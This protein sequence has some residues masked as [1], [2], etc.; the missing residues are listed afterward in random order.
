MRRKINQR[1]LT[2]APRW[3]LDA[4]WQEFRHG[5]VQPDFA[6][7]HHI[8][9]KER[10][11]DLGNG[12][13]LEFRIAVHLSRVVLVQGAIGDNALALRVDHAYDNAE[14]LSLGVNSIDQNLANLTVRRNRPTQ[15]AGGLPRWLRGGRSHDRSGQCARNGDTA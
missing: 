5:I 1:D 13:D 10:R 6:S 2:A 15:G 3:N 11:E 7:L 8:G 12:P 9:Q 14:R 4:S